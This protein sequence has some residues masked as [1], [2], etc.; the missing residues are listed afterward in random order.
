MLHRSKRLNCALCV[1]ATT[2][3]VRVNASMA[4][5][6]IRPTESFSATRIGAGMRFFSSV[7][8]DMTGLMF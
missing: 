8:T 1:V 2:V 3:W 5:Q 6:L 7:G 4:S